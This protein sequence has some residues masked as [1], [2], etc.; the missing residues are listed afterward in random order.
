MGTEFR[1]GQEQWEV[2][3]ISQL[4]STWS[5]MY[6]TKSVEWKSW[7]HCNYINTAKPESMKD[8][9]DGDEHWSEEKQRLAVEGA[10]QY[11][12]ENTENSRVVPLQ[13]SMLGGGGGGTQHQNTIGYLC[14]AAPARCSCDKLRYREPGEKVANRHECGWH[15]HP[16][17]SIP[18][19]RLLLYC[20]HKQYT[21]TKQCIRS[22]AL[23]LS[24][25][26]WLTSLSK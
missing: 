11:W 16:C 9:S 1:P 13:H 12:I 15:E 8:V 21:N 7:Q 22:T 18:I 14:N 20:T 24:Q 6:N 17:T 10:K 2:R 23:A 25:W 26:S 5:I 19:P 4:L 3:A